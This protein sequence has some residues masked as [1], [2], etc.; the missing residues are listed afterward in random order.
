MISPPPLPA[1]PLRLGGRG[2]IDAIEKQLE[3]H[4]EHVGPS[5]ETL[6]RYGNVSSASIWCVCVCVCV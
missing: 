2:V 3:L 1:P 6:F 5:R 4:P